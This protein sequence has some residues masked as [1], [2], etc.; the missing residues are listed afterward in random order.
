MDPNA[1]A[2]EQYHAATGF[3]PGETPP[4]KEYE[5]PPEDAYS[6]H[7]ELAN[8]TTVRYAVDPRRI[9][10]PFPTAVNGIAVSRVHNA[11]APGKESGQ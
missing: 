8:G 5:E 3:W 7:L 4:N 2:A 1:A 9:D 10:R 11:Y 6:H